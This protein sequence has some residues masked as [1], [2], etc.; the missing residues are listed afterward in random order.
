MSASNGNLTPY[1]FGCDIAIN[2]ASPGAI[3]IPRRRI[4]ADY[5]SRDHG[6][7]AK[8]QAASFAASFRLARETQRFGLSSSGTA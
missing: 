5:A 7:Q 3:V 6:D 1:D 4:V 2:R 8:S